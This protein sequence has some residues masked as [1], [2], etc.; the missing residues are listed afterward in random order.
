MTEAR[1]RQLVEVFDGY[2]EQFADDRL[3]QGVGEFAKEIEIRLVL[4]RV[5]EYIDDRRDAWLPRRD[6]TRSEGAGDELAQSRVGRR[7]TVQHR[8]KLDVNGL[9][10]IGGVD[11]ASAQ[12][13]EL[14]MRARL[15]A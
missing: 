14:L 12:L 3:W 4:E 13:A 1:R 10:D 2:A 9:D 11:V 15:P 5:D 6:G 8:R 7:I